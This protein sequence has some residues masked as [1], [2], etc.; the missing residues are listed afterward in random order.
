MRIIV[1]EIMAKRNLFIIFLILIILVLLGTY[2]GFFGL[3]NFDLKSLNF[4]GS[5]LSTQAKPGEAVKII[6]EESVTIDVVKKVSPSVVTIGITKSQPVFDFN[7]EFGFAR[8]VKQDIGS[9]FIVRSDGLI[10]TNKHVVSD[11][12]AKYR[13]VTTDNKSFDVE[14]IYRD[15][16]NDLAILKITPPAGGSNLPVVELGDSGKLQ[17]GQFAIAIGTALGEFRSTVTT[18]V[19]SGLSR[20]ITA[21]SPF[22]GSEKLDNVIQTSAAINPGNSGGPLLNSAG[23]VIGVNVAVASGAQNIGFALPINLLKDSLKTFESNGQFAS[24]AF[25]G[26][27]YRMVT[28]DLAILNEIPEGA[29]VSSVVE[30]SPA[31]KAG[32]EEGDIITKIDGKQLKDAE[33]GL[34]KIVSAKKP[35]DSIE[36]TIYRADNTTV[37]VRVKLEEAEQ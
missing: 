21:G 17:V 15:P 19:V 36:L 37:S 5:F 28:R 20:G 13:V 7:Q 30:D 10:I 29:Y 2:S 11:S 8:Q 26:V 33:G 3:R 14:K 24:R 32:V 16:N 22:E 6:T 9:G 12:Q 27:E 25:L 4:F 23:Q 18:G 31:S 1:F 35:G 34:A